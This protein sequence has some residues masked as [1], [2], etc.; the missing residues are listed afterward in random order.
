ML[1]A[2]M[3]QGMAVQPLF[4]GQKTYFVSETSAWQYPGHEH[5]MVCCESEEPLSL[6]P[7]ISQQSKL[8]VFLGAD[9]VP[10]LLASIGANDASPSPKPS[11][12][13]DGVFLFPQKE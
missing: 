9:A 11:P 5:E 7:A 3:E 4:P 13:G 12:G 2:T 6:A 8:K 10:R 1:A